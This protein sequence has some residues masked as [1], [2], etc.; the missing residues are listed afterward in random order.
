MSREIALI[1][2]FANCG[3]MF[4]TVHGALHENPRALQ[5]PPPTGYWIA[6]GLST[7]S[8]IFACSGVVK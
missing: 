4:G 2:I 5:K 7:I 1:V 6:F 3:F 8:T